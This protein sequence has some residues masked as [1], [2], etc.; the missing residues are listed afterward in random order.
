[1]TKYRITSVESKHSD[2]VNR[3]HS[4]VVGKTCSVERLERGAMAW[5]TVDGL[6]YPDQSALYRTS[7]V[8]EIKYENA[9]IVIETQNSLYTLEMQNG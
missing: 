4:K 3:W 6:R 2:H 5:F 8:L 9:K 7:P 1:M